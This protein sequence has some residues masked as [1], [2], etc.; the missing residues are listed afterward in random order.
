MNSC[1]TS[2]VW[3][4]EE[5]EEHEQ[6]PEVLACAGVVLLFHCL[7]F[8][9]SSGTVLAPSTPQNIFFLRKKICLFLMAVYCCIQLLYFFFLSF[10]YFQLNLSHF[11]FSYSCK[12]VS[13]FCWYGCSLLFTT[14]CCNVTN[15]LFL[16]SFQVLDYTTIALALCLQDYFCS[17]CFNWW[18]LFYCCSFLFQNEKWI[19]PEQGRF[20]LYSWGYCFVTDIFPPKVCHCDCL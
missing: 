17:M 12:I 7:F 14:F 8:F 4:L 15:L 5:K 10:G 20:L 6:F 11:S 13:F 19:S 1:F 3:L 16:V 18:S 2:W 9:L